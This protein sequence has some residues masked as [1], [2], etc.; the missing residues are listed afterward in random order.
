MILVTLQDLIKS[1]G[2]TQLKAELLA[3]L[4][5]YGFSGTDWNTCS[6][7]DTLVNVEAKSLEELW[8]IV[9]EIAKGMHLDTATEGWLTLLAKSQYNVERIPSE[10]TRGVATFSIIGNTT[11]TINPGSVIITDG[12][13]HN[14]VTDNS[15]PVTI[16]IATPIAEIPI[17]A[18]VVGSDYNVAPGVVTKIFQGPA[19]INVINQG[20]P[21]PASVLGTF[22][23]LV[24]P[25]GPFNLTGKTLN[26]LQTY[27]AFD[28]SIVYNNPVIITFPANYPTMNDVV[29]YL[30]SLGFF[31]GFNSLVAAN[32][33]GYLRISTRQ[34]GSI[35]NLTVS[36][37]LLP[38][39]AN[40]ILGFSNIADTT[41]FGG[42]STDFPAIV[43][44]AYLNPPFNVNGLQLNFSYTNNGVV[45]TPFVTYTANHIDLTSLINATNASLSG[46]NIQAFNDNGR[47]AIRTGP[48]GPG[49]LLI[50]DSSSSANVYF[51]FSTDAL[52]PTKANG[53]SSWITTE[54]RDEE[55]DDS[56]RSRCKKRWA[57]TGMGTRDAFETWAREAS[58]AVAKVAVYSNQLNGVPKAG[59]VTIYLA[60]LNGG[61]SS[62]VV[63]DVY[64]YILPKMPIM[65]DLYVGSVNAITVLYSGILQILRQSATPENLTRVKNAL[66][67]YSQSLNIGNP[68][69]RETIIAYIYTQF[70]PNDVASVNLVD[71]ASVIVT[72]QK[73]EVI[74]LQEDT[75]KLLKMVAV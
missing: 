46:T 31:I 41:S 55:L 66:T 18:Q 40:L 23:F 48:T 27:I 12:L 3:L 75:I 5:Q 43:Y 28:G 22:G 33:G 1:K 30:N 19:D 69:K 20:L 13:G 56:V 9:S 6:E 38:N 29:T 21:T 8:A 11:R 53:Y 35:P 16:N 36:L 61:V 57:I 15:A 65:S 59:A 62:S 25:P 32:E 73:N 54:G 2:Y 24:P 26:M 49:R 67:K 42:Y 44:S 58:T 74:I 63:T 7:S 17:I 10:F 60:G 71:P 39:A 47:L 4:T 14:Y 51:G 68:I 72:C 64:N 45:T 70:N 52:N 50:V 34:K 37:N